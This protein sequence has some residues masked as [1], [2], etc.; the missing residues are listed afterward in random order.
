MEFPITDLLSS[1]ASEQWL[2]EYFHLTGLKC[3]KCNSTVERATV[4]R[5]TRKSELKVFR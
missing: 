3:P 2:L 1:E 5:V 4:F